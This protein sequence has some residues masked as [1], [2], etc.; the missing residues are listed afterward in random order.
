MHTRTVTQQP[1]CGGAACPALE[2]TQTCNIAQGSDC[3]DGDDCTQDGCTANGVQYQCTNAYIC[4]GTLVI[5]E[6]D[7]DQVGFDTMEFVEL[8]N[9]TQGDVD[10]DEYTLEMVNGSTGQ[11]YATYDLSDAEPMLGPTE[12]LVIGSQDVLATIPTEVVS[13][14]L[15][16]WIQNGAPDGIRIVE[17]VG[18][19]LVDG[20]AYEGS[21]VGTGE[22]AQAPADLPDMS[23]SIGRCPDGADTDDNWTDFDLLTTPTPDVA[24]DCDNPLP[25]DCEVSDW[26][27]WSTCTET[28]GGGTRT[29][30]RS[31]ELPAKDGGAA[32]PA[33]EETQDCNTQ[34]CFGAC[35][36]QTECSLLTPTECQNA[37]GEWDGGTSCSPDPCE[38]VELC[39]EA[40]EIGLVQGSHEISSISN[41]GAGDDV[42]L[43]GGSCTGLP[44]DVGAGGEDLVYHF[45][46]ESYAEYSTIYLYCS[47]CFYLGLEMTMYVVSECG[48][49]VNTC[50]SGPTDSGE[51]YITI[52]GYQLDPPMEDGEMYYLIIDG[53][54]WGETPAM[55]LYFML[56]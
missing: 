37:N 3:D 20:L 14:E 18:G 53:L 51:S 44:G 55:D 12:L 34:S 43:P 48:D 22:G 50:V 23:T 49:V 2:D 24:N 8:Y 10:L 39:N 41:Y 31:I 35:C 21:M 40:I 27:D 47:Q 32:C 9:P 25:V 42:F 16:N 38:D 6:V 11:V 15:T 45:G 29:R 28:C 19:A 13:M 54:Y 4:E 17:A 26:S 36:V 5:N 7:Y 1:S 30:T 33:L 56:M 46:F 52:E